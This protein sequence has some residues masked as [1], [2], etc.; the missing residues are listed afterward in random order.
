[1]RGPGLALC[2]VVVLR[3]LNPPLAG[4]G[5]DVVQAQAE[6]DWPVM[7]AQLRQQL[8]QHPG[9]KT[10]RQQLAIAHNN[11]AISLTN[12]GRVGEAVQQLQQAITLE[13]SNTQFRTNL[14]RIHIQAAQ[15]AYQAHQ[16]QEA[17]DAIA[18]ALAL[19]PQEAAAYVLLGEIEYNSQRLKEAKAAWQQALAIDASLTDVAEK[20]ERLKQELVTA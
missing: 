18:R 19:N 1:M 7:I 5:E 15:V 14:A 3:M 13:P 12:Q 17:K 9:H 11:Y 20:L 10:T 6:T 4:A 2:F 16:I 8:Q